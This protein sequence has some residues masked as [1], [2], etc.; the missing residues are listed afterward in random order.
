M[1]PTLQIG[2]LAIQVPGLI[3]LASLWLGLL[4]VERYSHLYGIEANDLYNLSLIVLLAGFIGARV[5]YVLRYPSAFRASPLSLVSLNPGLLDPVG[6]FAVGMIIALAY[7][8]RKKLPLLL[9]LDALVPAFAV[10]NI[11]ISLA[12]L[13]SGKAFGAPTDLPWG[14]TLW[15]AQRHPTQIYNAIFAIIILFAFWPS[16]DYFRKITPGVTFFAFTASVAGTRL[17]LD[18]FRGDSSLTYRGVRI[19]QLVGWLILAISLVCIGWLQAKSQ[20]EQP[21]HS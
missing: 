13:C 6:G 11:G 16:H 12:N 4:V 7:G 3:L 15:G 20:H 5:A 14:I 8:Q 17:F 10:L 2:P 18:A 19:S 9:T 21:S 1:L